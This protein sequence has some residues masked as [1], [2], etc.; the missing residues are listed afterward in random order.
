MI[1]FELLEIA[2]PDEIESELLFH[3]MRILGVISEDTGH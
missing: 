2:R 3:F 1:C